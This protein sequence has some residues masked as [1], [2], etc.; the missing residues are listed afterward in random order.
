VAYGTTA[1]GC[2]YYINGLKLIGDLA[3]TDTG[4]VALAKANGFIQLSGNNEDGKGAALA[5]ETV[6]S[7]VLNGPLVFETRLE[8]AAV[9]AGVVFAGFCN[10]AADDVAEPMTSTTITITPVATHY[11]GFLLDSQFTATAEWHMPHKG[12]T[13]TA[14]TVST[15]CDSGVTAVAA[16]CNVLRLEVDSNGT[17]RWYI[18]G[19]LKQTVEDAVSTTTLQAAMVG[20]WGTTTTAATVDVDYIAIE[21]N[22]DWTV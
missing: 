9:T 10:T 13:A 11:A 1:G 16:S 3:E 4:A 22:R 6:F 19:V 18:D 20:C 8:R 17:C 2:N 5:S 7:P 12:G 21:Y 15:D 14:V